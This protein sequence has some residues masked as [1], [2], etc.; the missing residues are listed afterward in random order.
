MII[1]KEPKTYTRRLLL[2]TLNL[3]SELFSFIKCF[4]NPKGLLVVFIVIKSLYS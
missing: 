4:Q 3:Q 2:K 1:V